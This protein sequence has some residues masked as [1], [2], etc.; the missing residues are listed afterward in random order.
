MSSPLVN[1]IFA[2]D[3]NRLR[4]LRLA[5]LHDSAEA[6]GGNLDEEKLFTQ[7]HWREKFGKLRYLVAS[8]DEVDAGVMSIEN[9]NGDFGA[10]CWVGGCWTDPRFR[11]K[12]LMR[13]MFTYLDSRAVLNDWTIQGLGVWADNQLAINAYTALG[14]VKIG[15]EIASTK[16]PGKSY[17]RM[18]RKS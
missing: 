13:L 8:V 5:S 9:L 10:I 4:D 7:A 14:F 18:I 17:I 12:G 2:E 11:G 3:W 16:H 1:E 15:Q 6:F